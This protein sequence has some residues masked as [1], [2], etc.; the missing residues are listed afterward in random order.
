M[1]I[2]SFGLNIINVEKLSKQNHIGDWN[3]TF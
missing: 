2:N 3:K 1:A